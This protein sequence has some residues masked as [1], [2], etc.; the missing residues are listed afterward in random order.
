MMQV[1][2]IAAVIVAIITLEMMMGSLLGE[3]VKWLVQAKGLIKCQEQIVFE[4][5]SNRWLY[6]WVL[7]E[8]FKMQICNMSVRKET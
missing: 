6:R 3:G 5:R 1:S 4:I 8:T 2:I 7:S